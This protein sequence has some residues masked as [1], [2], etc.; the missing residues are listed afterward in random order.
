MKLDQL[1]ISEYPDLRHPSLV[2]AFAGWPDAAE[3]ATGAVVYLVRKLNA[4]KFAEIKADEFYDFTSFRP[5]V[6]VE[7][8][9]IGSLKMPLNNFFYCHDK[10]S[11][12]D[13]ILLHGIEPQ[14]NWQKFTELV[15]D[16]AEQFGV[17]RIY[18]LGGL[19]DQ[20]PHTMG[21]KI[22]GLANKVDVLNMLEKLDV[23]LISYQGPSSLHTLLMV[24]SAHRGIEAVSLW[25]H[26]PFYVRLDTNPIVCLGLLGKLTELLGIE[27]DMDD[28]RNAG[29]NL[30]EKL[31]R[32]LTDSDELRQYIHKLEAQYER[33]GVVS[34]KLFSETERI[35]K[36]VEDFLRNEKNRGE[37]FQ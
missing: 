9:I 3:V 13:L 8:G 17:A 34:E 10:T 36:E 29:E 25:G 23:E 11:D 2:A 18:I 32:L 15:L 28:L 12:N 4:M 20:T 27:V 30:Q 14:L 1:V 19:Y 5:A 22:T 7:G 31:I 33:D 24:A 21:P 16:L 37:T 35:V 6:T 26:C